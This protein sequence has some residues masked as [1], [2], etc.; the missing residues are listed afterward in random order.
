VDRQRV[1]DALG[2]GFERSNQWE[3]TL[4]ILAAAICILVVIYIIFVFVRN[5]TFLKGRW[6]YWRKRLKG[7][8]VSKNRIP[9]NIEIVIQL[10]F[11]DRPFRTK[12]HNLSPNGMF[13]KM[14]PP[15]VVGESF[16][17]LLNL[18]KDEKISAWAEVRWAQVN[19]TAFTPPGMGCKFF[20]ISDEDR[21]RIKKFLRVKD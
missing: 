21:N 19:R 11:E 6:I 5:Q 10:P 4:Q 14:N 16:R 7:Q 20:H 17:F 8:A 2:S 13:M 1:F 9:K 18:G 12:I 15:L 3:V